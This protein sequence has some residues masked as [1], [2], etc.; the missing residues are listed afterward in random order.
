M[1]ISPHTLDRQCAPHDG[2]T[3]QGRYV[4][5]YA[6]QPMTLEQE[7]ELAQNAIQPAPAEPCSDFLADKHDPEVVHRWEVLW[8]MLGFI[9]AGWRWLAVAA[10]V[11]ACLLVFLWRAA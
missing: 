10:I 6:N 5:N 9:A 3:Y 2:L 11:V 8:I 1:P 4:D 7:A